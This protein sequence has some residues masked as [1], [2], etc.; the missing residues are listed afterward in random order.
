MPRANWSFVGDIP[1]AFPLPEQQ[2]AIIAH[3]DR[4]TAKLDTLAAKYRRELELLAEYRVSDIQA[5]LER[6]LIGN[7]T[8]ANGRRG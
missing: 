6:K 5:F 7:D 4:E 3:I 8:P 1:L 2:D